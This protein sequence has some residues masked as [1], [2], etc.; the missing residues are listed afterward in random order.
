MLFNLWKNISIKKLS[1][2]AWTVTVCFLT[3]SASANPVGG[4]VTAGSASISYGP[5][6]IINQSSQKAIINWQSFNI[7]AQES[8]HFNQPAGG[9]ALNRISPL[10]GASQIYGRLTATG[11]IILINPAGVYFGPS[12][13][14][15]VGGLIATTAN[16]LDN[17]F[18]S[19]NYRFIQSSAYNGSIINEGT[20][21]AAQHGL[22][23]LVGNAVSNNGMIEANL[24]HAVLASGREFSMTLAGNSLIS[25]TVDSAALSRGVDQNGQPLKNGVSNAGRIIANGGHV[26]LSAKAAAGV[27]D[28]AINMSG[29]VEAQSFS[30][31]QDGR[32]F[33]TASPGSGSIKLANASLK[34]TASEAGLKG[35]RV[36]IMADKI[37]IE[38]SVIDVS[39]NAGGGHIQIGRDSSDNFANSTTLSDTSLLAHTIYGDGGFIET[40]GK[41]L[42]LNGVTI[43]TDSIYG[44][45]GTW[46]L[47]PS[48]LYIDNINSTTASL[49]G[50]T[51]TAGSNNSF[52]NI[53]DLLAALNNSNVILQ[54]TSAGSGGNGDIFVNTPINW[55]TSSNLTLSA[56]NNVVLNADITNTGG[57]SVKLIADNTG[58]VL[59]SGGLGRVCGAGSTLCG[60]SP[61]GIVAL[62]GGS[63]TVKVYYNPVTFGSQD[64]IYAGGTTPTKFML[65]NSLGGATDSFFGNNTRSLAT[66]SNSPTAGQL[67]NNYALSKDIDASA[68]ASWNGGQGFIPIRFVQS[69]FTF[70]GLSHTISNL[71]M[72]PNFYFRRV[73]LI[74]SNLGTIRDIGLANV[75]ISGTLCTGF[76]LACSQAGALVGTNFSGALIQNAFVNGGSIGF[77][78]N[79]G[80][81]RI[82]GLVGENDGTI[83]NSY[84]N[85]TVN[86]NA[87]AIHYLGGLVGINFGSIDNSYST[88]TVNGFTN[89]VV[90]GLVGY[91]L[92]SISNSYSTGAVSGA[93][94]VGGLVGLNQSNITNSYSTG[95]VTG[96]GQATGGLV[97]LNQSIIISSF[98]SSNVNQTSGYWV[99]GLV[100]SNTGAIFSSYS[101][102]SVTGFDTV[103]GLVGYNQNGVIDSYSTAAVNALSGGFNVGGLVGYNAGNIIN[104]QATT[105]ITVLGNSTQIGG[106]AGYNSGAI[107][108][109]SSAGS[110]FGNTGVGGLVGSS[111]GGNITNSYSTANVSA[112][113]WY[114]GGLV[115]WNNSSISDSYA[116]GVVNQLSTG[117]QTGGLIGYNN[118]S[119]TIVNSHSSGD[120]YG[121]WNAGGLIGGNAGTI[122]SSFS[123]GN[124]Y[125][126]NSTG[127]LVGGGDRGSINNSY[128]TGN[129]I[130]NNNDTGGL[131][132][133][134]ASNISDSHATGNVY[135]NV[136]AGGLTGYNNAT[137]TNSY[138]NG[139]VSTNGDYA[140]GLVGYNDGSITGSHAT[141][142]V[143][144][145]GGNIGGLVGQNN[146][147]ISDSYSTSDVFA[148]GNGEGGFAGSNYG[149]IQTSYSAGSVTGSVITGGL[150]GYNQG[151]ITNTYSISN[152]NG[153]VY[154]GGLV[155][156]NSGYISKSYSSGLVNGSFSVGGLIGFNGGSVQ[157]SF[158]DM[159]TSGQASS[160][161]GTG[162]TTAQLLNLSIYDNA[163]WNIGNDP[164]I[165]TWLIFDGQTRPM[166]A[167]EYSTSIKTPHALQLIDINTNTLGA[168]YTIDSNID[169]SV[170]ANPADIWAGKNFIAIGNNNSP[171]TGSVIGNGNKI[172][173][174]Y[175]TVTS[176]PSL[177]GTMSPFASLS[178][179]DVS[180]RYMLNIM[181]NDYLFNYKNINYFGGALTAPLELLLN[182]G[183]LTICSSSPSCINNLILSGDHY[184]NSDQLTLPV[185]QLIT[186]LQFTDLS[187]LTSGSI[188]DVLGNIVVD[189]PIAAN[190]P[191]TLDLDAYRN[192]NVNASIS[193]TGGGNVRLGID[194]TGVGIGNISFAPNINVSLSGGSGT[195]SL[196][197]NPVTFGIQDNISYSGGTAP[198]QYMLINSLGNANDT[199]T[200]SLATLSNRPDLWNENFALATDIDAGATSSWNGGAGFSPIGLN[201]P[202]NGKFDG[203]DHIISN[204]TLS[205]LTAIQTPLGLFSVAG[206]NAVISN[207]GLDNAHI[208]LILGFNNNGSQNTGALIG[209]NFGTVNN[210]FST[211][212]VIEANGEGT[213]N[214]IG[215]LIGYNAGSV[216]NAYSTGFI[217]Y[218]NG[219]IYSFPASPSGDAFIGGLIGY[220]AGTITNSYNAS[221]VTGN[222]AIGSLEAGGLTGGNE[223][224]INSSI[225]IA[226]IEGNTLGLV[227]FGGNPDRND[228]VGGLTGMSL[229]GSIT[230]SHSTGDVISS[231]V[232]N[233][234]GTGGLVGYNAGNISDSYATGAVGNII[235]TT[236]GGLVGYNDI[237]GTITHSL[238]TGTVRGVVMAGGLVGLNKGDIL[239]SF[240][241]STIIGQHSAGGL[242]GKIDSGSIIQSYS[243]G[244]VSYGSFNPNGSH[245]IGGLIGWNHGADIISDSY[246]TGDIT[247][248][249]FNINIGGL[250]GNN[251]TTVVNSYSTGTVTGSEYVGGLIGVNTGTIESSH[252]TSNVNAFFAPNIVGFGGSP[253]FAAGGLVGGSLAGSINNSYSTGIVTGRGSGISFLVLPGS[254]N[255]GGLVGLNN[256]LI[257]NSYASGDV[258]AFNAS[259]NTIGI[260]STGG[261]AGS[262]LGGSI[263]N[264]YSSGNVSGYLNVGG[265]VGTNSE[266]G[267]IDSSFSTSNV[268]GAISV[269]GLVGAHES[270]SISN[271]HSSGNVTG[272]DNFTG[273]LVGWSA[274]NIA[275][276]YAAGTVKGVKNV[277]GLLGYNTNTGILANSYSTS[278]VTGSDNNTGGLV[279]YN[280]GNVSDTYANSTVIGNNIVGGLIG[281]NAGTGVVTDSFSTGSVSGNDSVGG[282]VGI[283]I[284]TNIIASSYSAANVSGHN[285]VGGLIGLLLGDGSANLGSIS[286]SYSIGSVT[287]N[288]SVGGLIGILFDNSSVVNFTYS[289][290]LVTGYLNVGGLVGFANKSSSVTNSFWDTQTSGRTLSAGGTG[291]TTAQLLNI[292]TYSNAGWNIGTNPNSNTWLIFNGLT[293]PMLAMEYS[294]DI[295]TAHALQLMGLNANTLAA[296]YALSGNID[297]AA[298]ASTADIWAG[299]G[300]N[301]VGSIA[302]PFTGSFDGQN[303]QITNLMINLP[304]QN[305]VA[306]FGATSS[307]AELSNIGITGSIAGHNNVGLLVGFNAGSITNAY[308][309]GNVKGYLYTGG[310][311][312]INTGVIQNSYS[313]GSVKA[314]SI[315]GGLVGFNMGGSIENAYSIA[316]V[317]GSSN[318]AGG[319]VGRNTGNINNTYSSGLVSGSLSGGLAGSNQGSITNS[320]WDTVSSGKTSSAGGTGKTTSQLLSL[321]T[322]NNAGWNIGTDPDT[323]TWLIFNGYTRPLLSMEFSNIIT[324]AHQLQLVGINAVTS[325]ESYTLANN[326]DLNRIQNASDIWGGKAFVAIGN[327]TTPFTGS[328]D[329]A[330]Y[331]I[332]NLNFNNPTT[333]ISLIGAT[334][335]SAVLTDL[336]VSGRVLIGNT[337]FKFADNNYLGGAVIK[338]FRLLLN[339]GNLTICSS[340]SCSSNIILSGNR[341]GSNTSLTLPLQNLLTMMQ[342]ANVYIE[343]AGSISSPGDIAINAPILSSSAYNLA[344]N[345]WHDI[346]VNASI[347]NT[348]GGSLALS[349]GNSGNGTGT[350]RFAPSTNV[351]LSGGQG[352]VSIF[353]NPAIFGIQDAMYTGGTTADKYML[354]NGLGNASDTNTRTLATLSNR[355]D[356]WNE[357]F[358]L[359]KDIDAGATTGWNGGAGF[360]PIGYYDAGQFSSGVFFNGKFDGQ[361]H[362]ISNLTMNQFTP[363]SSS[364]GLF[365]VTG[366]NAVISNLG[367]NNTHM[368]V[369]LGFN[370]L[371][372]YDTGALI[373]TNFG[374][375]SNVFSTNA[376]IQTSGQ[377]FFNSIGGLIGSNRG[378]ISDAYSMGSLDYTTN[379]NTQIVLIGGLLG[380]NANEG[381]VKNTYSTTT[382]TS[383]GSIVP[384]GGL[385]GL[386]INNGTVEN[387]F[388]DTDTSGLANAFGSNSGITNNVTGGCF[389][390]QCANGGTINLSEAAT[391]RAAGWDFN[392]T[393]GIIAGKSY[394]YLLSVYPEAPRA[395]SGQV[396]QFTDYYSNPAWAGMAQNEM[397]PLWSSLTPMAL[398]GQTVNL[399][400]N[401]NILDSTT[402]SANGAYYFL[403]RNAAIADGT[404]LLTYLS[405]SANKANAITT[406]G[407][408][409]AST[410]SLMLALNTLLV[411]GN[412][413]PDFLYT[414]PGGK[415]GIFSSISQT[416][417][418]SPLTLVTNNNMAT[419]LGNLASNDVLYGVAGN[420]INVSD[421][422]N[423][424]TSPDVMFGL[425][426]NLNTTHGSITF[427]GAAQIGP[428]ANNAITLQTNGGGNIQT[429]NIVSAISNAYTL[430]LNSANNI[431]L[432]GLLLL[433]D[434][435][436]TGNAI[437]NGS[438]NVSA[439]Y[440]N[441]SITASTGGGYIVKDFNLLQGKWFQTGG[442]ATALGNFQIN[443]GIMPS[444][445][446]EYLQ[447][448]YGNALT[449]NFAIPGRDTIP[450]IV[451]NTT[452][453]GGDI[454]Y[455]IPGIQGTPDITVETIAQGYGQGT[456]DDP[457][458]I[459]SIQGLQG[460]GSDSYT[461]GL[462]YLFTGLSNSTLSALWNYN[463]STGMNEGFVPIGTAATP[464]TGTLTTQNAINGI[465]YVYINR[466][467][468]D[469]VGIFGVTGP[470]AVLSNVYLTKNAVTGNNNVAALVGW[471][472]G[473][474]T[475][476]MASQNFVL[477]NVN[478]GTLAGLNSGTIQDSASID[479]R[480]LGHIAG[481]I[482]GY[483]SGLINRSMAAVYVQGLGTITGGIAGINTGTINDSFFDQNVSGQSFAA[484]ENTGT[485]SDTYAGCYSGNCPINLS[486]PE[487]YLTLADGGLGLVGSS[488]DF[489]NIWGQQAGVSYP[490]LKQIFDSMGTTP[491][492]ISG[493]LSPAS[494]NELLVAVWGSLIGDRLQ[495]LLTNQAYLVSGADGSF[496]TMLPNNLFTP[497]ATNMLI[498]ALGGNIAGSVFFNLAQPTV[499]NLT[500]SQINIPLKTI[501]KN[502]PNP[503][504]LMALGNLQIVNLALG[505]PINTVA[506]DSAFYLQQESNVAFGNFSN[507]PVV[508]LENPGIFYA[509][510]V[511][512]LAQAQLTSS[513]YYMYNGDLFGD[514]DEYLKTHSLVGKDINQLIKEFQAWNNSL[515][516][517]Y[518]IQPIKMCVGY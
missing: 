105:S 512:A 167:M 435:D 210:V 440:T 166:L 421:N 453:P 93:G 497:G 199:S 484:G 441:Q 29:Y 164:N 133:W 283:G 360:T 111:N 495:S 298:T 74:S 270:G 385:I 318:Y 321:A 374:T 418:A 99:G 327:G 45:V 177:F 419:L 67:F 136:T 157:N 499:G 197:Y 187:I 469:N 275:D 8:T 26:I 21:I 437:T 154:S 205:P 86:G 355:S 518:D 106:L 289:S 330:G 431:Y 9:M 397:N 348:G 79:T 467:I 293:R 376:I 1:I 347:S 362:I 506:G 459:N 263:F 346:N 47:D 2:F 416:L 257:S 301:P 297:L 404:P 338:Q 81:G 153:G 238:S 387:S 288:D 304:L 482:A 156:Y 332:S 44:K 461:L 306:L 251:E 22:V 488:W 176:I 242:V 401:G 491:R 155:G 88:G 179:V 470:S 295:N 75:N 353:Y 477:G 403:T 37:E 146:N 17:D 274:A 411:Q 475:N 260:S 145:D 333:S 415:Q 193:N 292:T 299:K 409:G 276:S 181:G 173:A 384:A 265:L 200:R 503:T 505:L 39:G 108:S 40:S 305:V 253:S 5:N 468:M 144:G 192:L 213:F 490:Y 83:Q 382:T 444:A 104:G 445:V 307:S 131:V 114:T 142:N 57:A 277:G 481:G 129:V 113:G 172:T 282:L 123:T 221:T 71:T 134:N 286:N 450:P 137:I 361:G 400:T 504:Y 189:A 313:E 259:G 310:L 264:S 389:G 406:A 46:L 244:N 165:N 112:I 344:L 381:H 324:N 149:N 483:N 514:V 147:Y 196:F 49:S 457:Y 391:F 190:S 451:I 87:S 188:N 422:T 201:S 345:A 256:A 472:Q 363:Q 223:G 24:G 10:Q 515:I 27:L 379:S 343:T 350:V 185:D 138:S 424:V 59:S 110:V 394:P 194:N 219:N 241:T 447:L 94:T 132:G 423:F 420:Q 43:S 485:I 12:A 464:F 479:S 341:Y 70:D 300:F 246:A 101:T 140:G 250:I 252:S 417:A 15:R 51:Y 20:I 408:G 319:L 322:Y 180:A 214:N 446:A 455:I 36:D 121:Y 119:G 487:T 206:A 328:I 130:G 64:L 178:N 291:K 316:S 222:D 370:N 517:R 98:S 38:K 89:T 336:D 63:G 454:Q 139:D 262:N 365:G 466:P 195:V 162:A 35:G 109:S 107:E 509:G 148:S 513:N 163:S 436:L 56:F 460:I 96:N 334:S 258:Y 510:F 320:F 60:G 122:T 55:A 127:G 342:L 208:N 281:S 186:L 368:N 204:L 414:A 426:G 7:G 4:N 473:T 118:D 184:G 438:L 14:V 354:I 366:A 126:F 386:N 215:G 369:V 62:S 102:G 311:V 97:G 269:G 351:S 169:L 80:G 31:T 280:A 375:V 296:D 198:I 183:N 69:G 34:A 239:S 407:A 266:M 474:I 168:H 465:S 396:A 217:N 18:L 174:D 383:D 19:G 25:F 395:I 278:S 85:I 230:N 287:G 73:G 76:N 377:G 413:T 284:G 448:A 371:G 68:A 492:V 3:L 235:S 58:T 309:S 433:R 170:T 511:Y 399:V 91:N 359:S 182:P 160:P 225:N 151:N 378:S 117:F 392:N 317:T 175:G 240:S 50:D 171:F 16:M 271:S 216:T 331:K 425:T 516:D 202:F 456:P 227:F 272:S 92:S 82:G 405:N 478:V 308:G 294:A 268:T 432:K 220:N 329:G 449:E 53:N 48:D 267:S 507:G 33:L 314:A 357:N 237:S 226:N 115:G 191:Y 161:G 116:T 159:Q 236:I 128:S 337:E 496:Y 211:N 52:L 224:I 32:I 442:Y 100:G 103:G 393:W 489:S 429:D 41:N 11:Q 315:L 352:K 95:N 61:T 471:N 434:N 231:N 430:N 340:A 452:T 486:Q 234:T 255:I 364:T 312:G 285:G 279:G 23:A 245:D 207:L 326:L 373:G 480:V 54:T 501:P 325:G 248:V 28:H 335:P 508:P 402:T 229:G 218:S 339:P 13:Y 72:A 84:S 233:N 249:G 494:S 367:L 493:Q 349:S 500:G 443:S 412:G 120:V 427:N 6:T 135:G 141:G 77:A 302:T 498:S 90:G 209:S 66:L 388:W 463:S 439:A 254:E 143:S 261:L 398:S 356:L 290:G 462:S 125:G 428:L 303:N 158:W 78:A 502:N 65:I 212:G 372:S 124:V 152:V 42:A 390:G 203:K 150:V 380:S 358:A 273:D 458:I 410:T 30:K 228:Y 247:G 323:K 476:S 243:T 232:T